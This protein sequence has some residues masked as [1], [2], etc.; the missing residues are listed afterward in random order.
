MN[1]LL[2]T[3][4]ILLK[5][6]SNITKTVF[7]DK[8]VVD[9]LTKRTFEAKDPN[10]NDHLPYSDEYLYEALKHP[11][12]KYNVPLSAKGIDTVFAVRKGG[13]Y[14]HELANPLIK[15]L[16]Q[17]IGTPNNALCMFYPEDGY[18]GWHHNGNAHGYNFLLTYSMDG[19]GYFRY[20]DKR[21]DTFTTLS[22]TPGWNFRF[23][24]YSSVEKDPDDL[25]WHA[26]YT[27]NPRITIGFIVPDKQMW[28]SLI[29]ECVD[30]IPDD[31][32]KY[33]PKE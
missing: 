4:T 27:K 9:N 25:F 13:N 8:E 18:I 30:K 15:P 20:Y 5:H 10:I 17:Y 28:K 21:T 7:N 2:M 11:P 31:L 19:D 22:D 16:M 32:D 33:G 14:W 24:Y 3:N 1:Q 29:E 23:G 26:A 12:E 6:L